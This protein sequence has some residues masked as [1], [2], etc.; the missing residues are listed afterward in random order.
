[1]IKFCS[2]LI[3]CLRIEFLKKLMKID[4]DLSLKLNHDRKIDEFLRAALM[5]AISQD[6]VI[7][8]SQERSRTLR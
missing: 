4:D 2:G 6:A 8:V 1:M 3:H 5:L 7:R